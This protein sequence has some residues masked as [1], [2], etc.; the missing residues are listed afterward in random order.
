[1]KNRIGLVYEDK[2]A[3]DIWLKLVL[4]GVLL[5]TF[6]S[7]I[8]LLF[9]EPEGAWVMFG[10]TLFLALLFKA[11]L[12]TR[13]QIF[14]DRIRIVLGGPFAMN[15]PF[16]SIKEVRPGSSRQTM[17]YS[18]LRFATSAKTVV[19]ITRREGMNVV[20]S[21]GKREMFLEQFHQAYRTWANSFKTEAMSHKS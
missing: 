1:M 19:E 21:P 3:Y 10:E 9:Q 17:I 2:P 4:G 16:T 6:V 20:I 5:I 18:G 12:P 13:H 8:A 7:G 14:A 15:I 11:I